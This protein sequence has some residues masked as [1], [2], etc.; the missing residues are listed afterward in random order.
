MK[1]R[2]LAII[3][4]LLLLFLA[5]NTLAST[6]KHVDS[7]IFAPGRVLVQ[8]KSPS[9]RQRATFFAE[10]NLQII[11]E[12][13][14]LHIQI[15]AVPAGQEMM[16]VK[17]LRRLPAVSFAEL[18]YQ[19]HTLLTP[20]DPQFSRQWNL[21]QINAPAGWDIQTGSNA[22]V[23]AI[24]DTGVDLTHPDLA[25]KIVAGYNFVNNNNQPQDDNGHGTH[26]A[27]IAA[28]ISNNGIGVAGVDWA[29]RI[30]PL[31]CLNSDGS[32]WDSDI[33]DATRWAVDHGAKVINMS[34]GSTTPSATL[35]NAIAYAHNHDVLVVAAAG[36]E[37]EQDNNIEYPAA[38]P[39]VMAV[40]AT[41]NQ[42]Q[43]A[44]YS[45]TG[46]YIDIAAPGGN[47]AAQILSTIWR[48]TGLAYDIM[49]GT[50]MAT[51][52]VA[53]LAALVMA[54]NPQLTADQ[55]AWAIESSATDLGQA[56]R[57]NIFGYGQIDMAAALNAAG[58][59]SPMPTAT[60][61]PPT[62]TPL[63]GDAYEPDN[64]CSAAKV[65]QPGIIQ[66]HN[67][68]TPSDEDWVG[69]TLDSPADIVLQTSNLTGNTDTVLE[70]Y[71]GN[72]QHRLARDD[73]SGVGV[74]S[75]I[76]MDSLPAGQYY[77]RVLL[78]GGNNFDSDSSYDLTLTNNVIPACLA[79]SAHPYPNNLDRT[80]VI[81]N[82]NASALTSRVHF[83]RIETED[84]YDFLD[85]E[86][87][88]GQT[89]Q[90]LTGAY[91][92]WWSDPIPGRVIRLRLSSD[93]SIPAWGFCADK[94][95]TVAN[96]PANSIAIAPP[97]ATLRSGTIIPLLVTAVLSDV[98]DSADFRLSFDPALLQ[99]VDAVGHP[100]DAIQ[101]ASTLT[102]TLQNKVDNQAGRIDFGVGRSP[103]AAPISGTLTLATFYVQTRG[104]GDTAMRFQSGTAFFRHGLAIPLAI[105]NGH[106]H[107]TG[108]LRGTAILEGHTPQHQ[109]GKRLR[110][111]MTN[112]AGISTTMT[113]TL[114]N[115]GNFS[116]TVPYSGTFTLTVKSAHALGNRRHHVRIP[117]ANPVAMGTLREG[118]A[119]GNNRIAG[120]DYSLLVT[121]FGTTP[122]A[123]G[124]DWRCDFNDDGVIDSHD[125]QQIV[126]NYNMQGPMEVATHAQAILSRQPVTL[127]LHSRNM[128]VQA[129]TI[130]TV[131]IA[132][133]SPKQNI[134]VADLVL[135]WPD[136][137]WR[138]LPRVQLGSPLSVLLHQKVEPHILRVS[139]GR[140]VT[141][142]NT[143]GQYTVT[144]IA[145]RVYGNTQPGMYTMDLTG[146]KLF[147]R[148]NAIGFTA[149]ALHITIE[150]ALHR[151]TYLPFIG[152]RNGQ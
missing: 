110:L 8:L 88:Q 58:H 29:A 95:A 51:P 86:D 106:Y 148:G 112:G 150:N 97:E 118:D 36:N 123:T 20:N 89:V 74:A 32:G 37:F 53:G 120:A 68:N 125:F 143:S 151:T 19:S 48:G 145:F 76:E 93:S 71:D 124:W 16:W 96:R 3:V 40:A 21:R 144:Q 127:T 30:M 42:N 115:V 57:D 130:F 83:W 146:S 59:L 33:A 84:G 98:V 133:H 23:I 136:H 121:A 103:Q 107:I 15:V 17:R 56:G 14:R 62:P 100:V 142:Q 81:T 54:Q 72:C 108:L 73:D 63:P 22:V 114:D 10:R 152:A 55:V 92:D 78:Y 117:T 44:S 75:R 25:G 102:V 65:I 6:T 27:G 91:E 43:H 64:N 140:P 90:Q 61:A 12:I 45:N 60:P 138:P 24:I 126:R 31:K 28:A 99:I 9:P 69:F 116:V 104:A 139:A 35:A 66:H 82:S 49:Y 18:D 80:W 119:N 122:G 109:A 77:G 128:V 70:L 149:P 101:P 5:R 134:D 111:H 131:T 1:K 135:H 39:Y 38:F 113:T 50:S 13:K 105:D 141:P 94:I 85:I 11:R 7:T 34:F 26:V 87:R 79:E 4:F 137:P 46:N 47:A 2:F 67:F 129:G 52:H 132:L 41:N 147:Y